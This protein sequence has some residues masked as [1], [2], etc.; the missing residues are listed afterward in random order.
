M[1]CGE[2]YFHKKFKFKDG[3][4]GEKLFVVLYVSKSKL[5][6]HYLVCT[7]TTQKKNKSSR[8]GCQEDKALFFLPKN[9]DWFREDTWLQFKSIYPYDIQ[10]VLHNCIVTREIEY[11]DRLKE[12]TFREVINCIKRSQDVE[13]EYQDIIGSSMK[14]NIYIFTLFV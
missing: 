7:V 4:I 6:P 8:E 9:K 10:S 2:I 11:K 1:K 13:Q 14:G 5:Q 12:K 3:N